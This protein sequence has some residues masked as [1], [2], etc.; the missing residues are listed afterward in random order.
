[1]S[2]SLANP[3]ATLAARAREMTTARIGD[4]FDRHQ[5]RLLCLA[6][7]LLSDPEEARDLV[8]GTFLR[9]ARKPQS[10]PAEDGGAEAWL[11]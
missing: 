9:A 3:M 11:V 8:Q 2:E 6:R 10:L 7:R 5:H 4:L 1:M